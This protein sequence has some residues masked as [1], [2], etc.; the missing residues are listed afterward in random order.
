MKESFMAVYE[1]R[2]KSWK[3]FTIITD[4]F[5]YKDYPKLLGKSRIMRNVACSVAYPSWLI[6]GSAD[7]GLCFHSS[8]SGLDFP[9]KVVD[10]LG[11]SL[12]VL[13]LDFPW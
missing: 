9:M 10:M 13:A 3:R 7:L 2:K 11:C 4:W 5:E 1:T 8:S 12:P 6:L